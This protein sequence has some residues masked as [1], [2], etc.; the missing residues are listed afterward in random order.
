MQQTEASSKN[1]VQT[2]T[3]DYRTVSCST[4]DY[5]SLLVLQTLCFQ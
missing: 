3:C 2:N 5:F 1:M 4:R